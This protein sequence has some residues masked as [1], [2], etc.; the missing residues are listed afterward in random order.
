MFR[1]CA[2]PSCAA[3][4]VTKNAY[5]NNT[6]AMWWFQ[7]DQRIQESHTGFPLK[8]IPTGAEPYAAVWSLHPRYEID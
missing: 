3:R 5:V 4:L 8:N 6:T 7:P 1:S 2:D